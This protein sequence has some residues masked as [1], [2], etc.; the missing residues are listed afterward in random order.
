MLRYG[1]WLAS[2]RAAEQNS[3]AK[4]PVF[5]NCIEPSG[6]PIGVSGRRMN[7]GRMRYNYHNIKQLCSLEIRSVE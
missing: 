3:A 6:V 1:P 2:L 4:A 7:V 5:R